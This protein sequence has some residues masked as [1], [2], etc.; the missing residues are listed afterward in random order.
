[1]TYD[2]CV[3]GAPIHYD[4]RTDAW[5]HLRTGSVWCGLDGVTRAVPKD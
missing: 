1:M 5:V 3:C 4:T 2:T